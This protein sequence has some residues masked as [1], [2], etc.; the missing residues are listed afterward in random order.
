MLDLLIRPAPRFFLTGR[1]DVAAAYSLRR[2]S[3]AYAGALVRVRRSSDSAEADF[4]Y[5]RQTPSAI[6]GGISSFIGA[7]SGFVS[8]W[9]DQSGLGRDFSQSTAANQPQ[10]GLLANGLPGITFNGT[11][12]YLQATFA[13]SQPYSANTVTRRVAD[14]GGQYQY[15]WDGK[16]HAEG[17]LF[18]N[19]TGTGGP[20]DAQIFAG[21]F[22]PKSDSGT[23]MP[24]GTRGAIGYVVNGASSRLEI[25]AAAIASF[26]GDAGSSS[27]TGLTLGVDGAANFTFGGNDEFQEIILFNTAHSQAQLKAD[28]AAMRSAWRF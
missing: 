8:K 4:G 6:W 23:T 13:L 15:W 28:N 24:T 3:G 20:A 7:G 25:N 1:S 26:T 16:V 22:G 12:Q 14:N 18:F 10:I 27:L 21:S 2:L 5:G 19:K 9:Y 11:S 17:A